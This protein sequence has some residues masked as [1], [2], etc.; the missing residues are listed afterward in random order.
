VFLAE[1][2]SLTSFD[3]LLSVMPMWPPRPAP[4]ARGPGW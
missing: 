4:A 1:F 3:L 2:A